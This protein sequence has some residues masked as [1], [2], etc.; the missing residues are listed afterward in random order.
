MTNMLIKKII[1]ICKESKTLISM[2]TESGKLMWIGN[3]YAAYPAY[4]IPVMDPEEILQMHDIPEDKS[5]SYCLQEESL[6][7]SPEPPHG[8]PTENL[9]EAMPIRLE[10]S[11]V[12]YQPFIQPMTNDVYYIDAAYFAPFADNTTEKQYFLRRNIVTGNPLI[13][14][15][16]G[17]TPLAAISPGELNW[18]QVYQNCTL[19][20]AD[21][22][23]KIA[24]QPQ[25]QKEDDMPQMT[26]ED[27]T[28]ES[29]AET[30]D[31]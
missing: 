14:V 2:L 7:F 8:E 6:P 26:M 19:L 5:L 9:L 13:M 25:Q 16:A 28:A 21:A 22:A 1:S 3:R 15:F 12:S 4:S 31:E 24:L 11:G 27:A 10:I 29:E 20:M 18:E 17:L 23:N 30:T